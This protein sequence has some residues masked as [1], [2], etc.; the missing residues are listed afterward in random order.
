M[1]G[2][3]SSMVD[4][5]GALGG[6]QGFSNGRNMGSPQFCHGVRNAVI[7]LLSGLFSVL[8][9]RGGS[10]VLYGRNM[11]SPQF[12]HS[13][14]NAVILLLS[15]VFSVFNPLGGNQGF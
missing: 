7:L 4:V 15:G 9:P 2:H 3:G 10:G 13:V 1:M 11:G 6:P 5:P 12:C 14:R 8:D